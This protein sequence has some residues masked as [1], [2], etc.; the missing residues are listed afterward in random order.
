MQSTAFIRAR[1]L[2]LI[3]TTN[4][5]RDALPLT[6]SPISVKVFSILQRKN[7][8]KKTKKNNNTKTKQKRTTTTTIKIT[9]NMYP[10]HYLQKYKHPPL[11]PN[12]KTIKVFLILPSKNNPPKTTPT[13]NPTN[14]KKQY[15]PLQNKN[16][17]KYQKSTILQKKTPYYTFYNKESIL[18]SGDIERNP[19]PKF[20]LLLNHPQN[21]QEKYN[22]YFYKNTIQLK[23]KYEHIFELF[24]PYFKV[25]H[26]IIDH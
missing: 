6:L 20:T 18:I 4:Y 13:N 8:N 10:T 16:K 23:I 2:K 25:L 21:H 1:I 26:Q 11:S 14:P 9:K 12:Q 5:T 24:K 3:R 17:K 15:T 19:G 7:K 22:T